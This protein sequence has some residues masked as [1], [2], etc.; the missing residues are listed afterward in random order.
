MFHEN[1]KGRVAVVT[2][3]GGV[4]C[5]GFARD[6][7]NLGVKV[8]VLDLREEAAQK[9][10]DEITAAGGTAVAVACNVLEPESLEAAKAKVNETFGKCDILINGA[11][12]NSPLGTTTKDTLELKDMAEKAEGVKTFFDLDSKGIEFFESMM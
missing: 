8:A 5:S 10:V 2:G 11:G 9:V 3:G 1:L 7:A 6:L 4:L 12:G